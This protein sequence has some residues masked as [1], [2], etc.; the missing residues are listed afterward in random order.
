MADLSADISQA[1]SRLDVIP[2]A[3]FEHADRDAELVVK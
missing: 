1:T 3:E 2:G